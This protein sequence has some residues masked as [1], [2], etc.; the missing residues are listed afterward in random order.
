MRAIVIGLIFAA[1]ILAGGTA[2]MLRSY[3]TTQRAEFASLTPKTPTSSVMVAAVN[4]PTGTVVNEKNVEWEPW[5]DDAIQETFLVRK[6]KQN[7][8][9][10]LTKDKHVTRYAVIKGEPIT[11]AKLYKT[12]DPGFLRG[13]ITPGMRAVSVRTSAE[14]ASSGF[15]LPG[16]HVDV[17]LTH[18]LIRRA[19][20]RMVAEEPS[21]AIRVL[22]HTSETILEDIRVLAID[23]K[24]EK[25]EAGAVIAK[26]ILLEATPKQAEMLYT[27]KSMGKVSLILR[28]AE[29]GEPRSETP[30]TTDVEVSPILNALDHMVHGDP[31]M[32]G[33]SMSSGTQAE[34]FNQTDTMSTEP[35]PIAPPETSQAKAPSLSRPS[36]SSIPSVNSST[37][38]SAPSTTSAAPSA[39]K[40]KISIYRGVGGSPTEITGSEAIGTYDGGMTEGEG[41]T[42]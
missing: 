29:T 26:T 35:A 2:Y 10:D 24:V 28:S 21:T 37:T 36:V 13:A 12:D 18:S 31:Q 16:D 3:L 38:S 7:P 11:M 17:L 15:I 19:M 9:T 34:Y 30:Y 22:E 33:D 25:F 39:P 14:N 42:E 41:A 23:Q 5:P 1:V 32:S 6:D 20:D 40:R 27:A 8:L 4:M